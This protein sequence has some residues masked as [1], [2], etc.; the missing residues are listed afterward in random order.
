[1]NFSSTYF[2]ISVGICFL[3]F[4]ESLGYKFIGVKDNSKRV[5]SFLRCLLL[6]LTPFAA[7]IIKLWATIH[8]PTYLVFKG[9]YMGVYAFVALYSFA[10]F[11][12][13]TKITIPPF[14]IKIT[15]KF[16]EAIP[17]I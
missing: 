7:C 10:I 1:M 13:P 14:L 6:L 16:Y 15:N 12:F 17:S 4:F 8:H 5:G 3:A 11:L 2:F 9:F